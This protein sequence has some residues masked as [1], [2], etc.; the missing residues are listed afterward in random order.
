VPLKNAHAMRSY[1]RIV[2]AP[3]LQRGNF[4]AMIAA[5]ESDEAHSHNDRLRNVGRHRRSNQAKKKSAIS[6]SIK[7][8]DYTRGQ[9][10]IRRRGPRVG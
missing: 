8:A 1:V 6:V 5:C 10:L 7:I 3:K 2:A 9:A 4:N